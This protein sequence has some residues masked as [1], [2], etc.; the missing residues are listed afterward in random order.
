[1]PEELKLKTTVESK[2]FL[3]DAKLRLTS[4]ATKIATTDEKD[5]RNHLD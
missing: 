2:I 3:I 4:K 1:M 5:I